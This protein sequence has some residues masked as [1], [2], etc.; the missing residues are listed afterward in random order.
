MAV[1]AGG[2]DFWYEFAST[3]SYLA[4]MRIEEQ[5]KATGVKVRWRPFLLGPVFAAQGWNNSPFNIYE[6]KGNYMWRDMQREAQ[7]LGIEFRKPELFPQSGLIAARVALVGAEEGWIAPFSRA[8]YEAEFVAGK[9]IS[10][11]ETIADILAAM[12][13]DAAAIMDKAHAGDIK[14]RLRDQTEEAMHRGIFGA[15]S[16][17]ARDGELFWGNDRLAQALAWAKAHP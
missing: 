5:A 4:A 16:F 9:L 15:P 14:T 8:V 3:Y 10:Q 2:L 1:T 13:L 17:T 11:T 7:Q 12:E 6:A